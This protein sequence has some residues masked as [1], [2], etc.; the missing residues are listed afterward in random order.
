MRFLDY[1]RIYWGSQTS[2]GH[3]HYDAGYFRMY[4]AELK[5]LYSEDA[6]ES[7][8]EI[9]CGAGDLYSHLGFDAL[10]YRGVDFSESMLG[11]FR[12]RHPGADLV[13]AVGHTYRDDRRYDLV[14]SNQVLQNF[15]AQMMEE[16]FS[17]AAAMLRPGGVLVCGSLPLKLNRHAFYSGEIT[18]GNRPSLGRRLWVSLLLLRRDFIGHWFTFGEILALAR[19]HGFSAEFYGCMLYPYRFHAVCRKDAWT[20]RSTRSAPSVAASADS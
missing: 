5:L 12:K 3:R 6:I 8:L 10:S 13:C 17:S 18:T 19:R 9:G 16:H 11:E 1:Y 2:A 15:D 14:F 7:V 20:R 4:S